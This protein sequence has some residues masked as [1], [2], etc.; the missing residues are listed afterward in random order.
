M[1]FAE[2]ASVAPSA[3]IVRPLAM[4]SRSRWRRWEIITVLAPNSD[5]QQVVR[6]VA[7]AEGLEVDLVGRLKLALL[8]DRLL[9]QAR[10]ALAHLARQ[11]AV[12]Q[13]RFVKCGFD[14]R[15]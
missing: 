7:A 15:E 5:A 1:I 12:L 11:L 8:E 3:A 13:R 4:N 6:E 14:Q 9:R 10:E 2:S